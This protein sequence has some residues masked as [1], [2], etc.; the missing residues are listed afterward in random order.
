MQRLFR[1]LMLML[2]AALVAC[3]GGGD[4]AGGNPNQPSLVTTAGEAITLSAYNKDKP[5]ASIYNY[6][7]SGG[8][9]PYRIVDASPSLVVGSVNGNVLTIRVVGTDLKPKEDGSNY[10]TTISIMDYS[11]ATKSISV[12]IFPDIEKLGTNAPAI[13][14]LANGGTSVYR[15][16]GGVSEYSAAT[17]D[18]RIVSAAVDGNVLRLTGEGFGEGKVVLRDSKEQ[19]VTIDVT[20]GASQDLFTDAPSTVTIP[21]ERLTRT[22]RI[23]GGSAPYS[24]KSSDER[25]VRSSVSGEK[26]VLESIGF[27]SATIT[28]SDKDSSRIQIT[29]DVKASQ[30]LFTT[31][32]NPVYIVNGESRSYEI[33]GGSQPYTA[34]ST[35]L[36]VATT[37]VSGSTLSITA[38]G[39]GKTT[40]TV[41]DRDSKANP[42][43]VNV[44]SSTAF[45][46]NAPKDVT[47]QVGTSQTYLLSGGTTPYQV[48]S[49][50]TSVALGSIAGTTLTV[51][52]FKAGD[53]E[54]QLKDATGTALSLKVTVVTDKVAVSSDPQLRSAGL[55]DS[56]GA[57]TNAIS[58]SGYTTLSVT[59]TDPSGR[60]LSNQLITVSGDPTQVSFP[61]SASGL[62]NAE[63][64]ATIKL[65]RASL[66]ATGAGSLTVTYNYKVGSITTYPDG[67][68]PPAADKIISTYVGYQL[69]TA[70][71]TLVN[72]NVGASTLAAYGTRQVSVQANVNDKATATPVQINFTTTCG[73]V[74]PATASTNSLGIA[75]VSYSATDAAG[76]AT[77]TQGCSG[78][79]VE[80]SAS[81]IGATVKTA[82][83]SITAAPATNMGFVSATPERIYLANSGGTTQSIV[84]FKLVNAQG[85]VI[86]GQDVILTLKTLNGG[87]PKASFGTV[88]NTSA[89]TTT[90]DSKGE[91]SVPVFSGTVPTS[92]LIN[93]A[94][95]SNSAV[96][97][98]SAALSIA[99]GRPSQ[100]RV[101]LALE[102]LSIEGANIDGIT[103]QVT[104][105]LADRQ[106][107]PVPDGTAVNFVTEGGAIIPPVCIIGKDAEG[108]PT[109]AGTS[110]CVVTIRSQ[111]PRSLDGR[112]SI[113]AYA[114]G[115]EDFV[116]TNANNVYDCGESFT[117]F[118]LGIAYR[119]DNDNGTA[120]AG[121][122]SIPRAAS[123]STCGSGVTPTTMNGDGVWGAA[124]VRKQ[125][126]IIFA[127][128][129]ANIAIYDDP[130]TGP[131]IVTKTGFRFFVSDLH[132]VDGR[133]KNSMPVGTT[134]D[135]TE[136]D[137]TPNAV[138]PAATAETCVIKSDKAWKVTNRLD[139]M[140]IGVTL[141]KC[142]KDDSII[143]KVTSPS[144]VI[145]PKVFTIP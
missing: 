90:T 65:V 69:A 11:G 81:T 56:T 20:V 89:V 82:T 128:S 53:A 105:F 6:Q 104:F 135:I 28:I 118:D 51:S 15:I 3:G 40:I 45:F 29:V 71:I 21:N 106:G 88:G 142:N 33:T 113:L 137:N 46:I 139:P 58:T 141:E 32:P 75:T 37:S 102:K 50:N 22:Y 43:V 10:T 114:S 126:T 70:N 107:N 47:L 134:I 124:D 112:V 14:K 109:A 120:D 130:A 60:G 133:H 27:G 44:G 119:D 54:L 83:L 26:L 80:I 4:S 34:T 115:E 12:S 68:A 77:S 93:A 59:L 116:D 5:E 25:I 24:A 16:F 31:A 92:V 64:V 94:L 121:E 61:E 144:G 13:V 63:G 132:N 2:A 7:I 110:Q 49:S 111:N 96:Q 108:K 9:P 76:A 66:A 117:G 78:K 67:S 19:S 123:A 42:I 145:T 74:L 84:K 125:G 140:V 131:D 57:T 18:A 97:T 95:K 122:F 103:S 101:S 62:T 138:A 72:L 55:K 36:T 41:S 8:V 100:A 91:L 52:A 48:S 23:S 35:D 98:D 87:I 127:T 17:S 143:V 85:E 86:S 73:Q 129:G 30:I 99:S 39:G 1:I 38:V 136:V 79:T